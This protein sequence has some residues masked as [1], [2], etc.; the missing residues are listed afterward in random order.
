MSRSK[1]FEEYVEIYVDLD[2]WDTEELIAELKR[3]EEEV[4]SSSS[5]STERL[6]HNLF[7]A[8]VAKDVRLFNMELKALFREV[9]GERIT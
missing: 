4:V 6:I 7:L 3:R 2:E 1:R 5:V 8:H 9:L